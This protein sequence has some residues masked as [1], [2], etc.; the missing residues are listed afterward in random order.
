MS[1]NGRSNPLFPMMKPTPMFFAFFFSAAALTAAVAPAAP[2]TFDQWVETFTREWRRS[3]AAEE[4]VEPTS[5]RDELD[6]LLLDGQ[7]VRQ[8]RQL[9][10]AKKGIAELGQW[11]VSSLDAQQRISS[12]LLRW[13]LERHIAQ[14]PFTEHI[15]VFRQMGGLHVALV[16]ALTERSALLRARDVET[17]LERLGKVAS[18]IGEGLARAQAAA[19]RGLIPPRFILQR[20]QQQLHKFLEPAAAQN[21]F[22]TSLERRSAG[23][24]DLSPEARTFAIEK[25]TRLVVQQVRPAY[26]RVQAF[27]NDLMPR[28]TD[29]PGISQRPDGSAA[30]AQALVSYTTTRLTADDIHSIGLR[31]VARLEAEVDRLLRQLG[32]TEGSFS[33]RLARA[34]A[35]TP[36]PA[37]P[38]PRAVLLARYTAIIRDAEKRSERLF[39]LKPRASVEARRVP[40]LAER[41]TSAYYTAPPVDGSRGGIFWVPLPGPAFALTPRMRSLAYHEA[42]PGHHFQF[43]IQQELKELPRFRARLSFGGISAHSEGWAMYVERLA[44]EQGWYDG[45]VVGLLGALSSE[46][47]RAKRLVVDTGLHAKRWTRQQAL[48]YG[49]SVTEVERNVVYPGQACSYMIGLL[50]IVELREKA[51]AALGPRFSLPA[52]HDLILRTGTVPLDLLAT[53]VEDWIT[54]Q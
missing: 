2:P 20:T 25:A 38:D 23:V 35:G 54:T 34:M 48:D 46:L 5:D 44:V 1:Q 49:S 47:L 51:R 30:Y 16:E 52:F 18:Q 43:A 53:V 15:F 10:L 37:E 8:E 13:H 3:S 12:A 41:T 14:Q 4:G 29:D 28:A 40:V 27:I 32:Y 33:V 22:V 24:A 19:A 31:E 39:N 21:V 50:R 7:N 11:P 36:L 9:A 42:V 6:A 45:D 26:E 17:Y